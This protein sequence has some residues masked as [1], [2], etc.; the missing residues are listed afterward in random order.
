MFKKNIIQREEKQFPD[1]G[2]ERIVFFHK[3]ECEFLEFMRVRIL[4]CLNEC[5]RIKEMNLPDSL[6]VFSENDLII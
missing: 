5:S 1:F 4:Y 3:P 6:P 2:E